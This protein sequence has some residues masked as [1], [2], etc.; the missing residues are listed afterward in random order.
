[1]LLI[2]PFDRDNRQAESEKKRSQARETSQRQ[3]EQCTTPT[4][5]NRYQ[6]CPVGRLNET[7]TFGIMRWHCTPTMLRARLEFHKGIVAVAALFMG[8][9]STGMAHLTWLGV[10]ALYPDLCLTNQ[11]IAIRRVL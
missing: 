1:M 7:P 10:N 4:Y 8:R 6:Q 11:N 3:H 9:P 5:N 2:T